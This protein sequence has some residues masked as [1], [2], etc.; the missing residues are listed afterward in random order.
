MRP[1]LFEARFVAPLLVAVTLSACGGLSGNSL[2]PSPP[3]SLAPSSLV[4]MAGPPKCAREKVTRKYGALT[5]KLSTSGGSV[6]VPAFGRFSG[7]IEYPPFQE[8]NKSA[9]EGGPAKSSVTLKLITSTTNYNHQLP[10]I[11]YGYDPR[12]S[13]DHAQV[14]PIFYLQLA[15]S[16]AVVFG[17]SL[18]AGGGLVG[19][20]LR[21][22]QIYTAVAEVSIAGEATPIT[23]CW[24]KAKKS[25]HGGI[26][27]GLGTLLKGQTFPAGSTGLIELYSGEHASGKC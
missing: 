8:S 17:T 6:C 20:K 22:D 23:P 18:R 10:P 9:L 27:G 14:K 2:L 26:V 3:S 19:K 1:H 21:P 4:P 25:K 7:S 24:V 16:S 12:A 5:V 11:G 13:L 15:I